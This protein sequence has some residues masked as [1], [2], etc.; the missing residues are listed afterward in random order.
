MS[1]PA[2]SAAVRGDDY[3]YVVAWNHACQA[4][5]DPNIESVSVED[6]GAGHFDDLAIRRL[7]D[8][9]DLYFQVKSSNSGDVAVDDDWLT[10]AATHRGRSP[11]QHFH[12]TW[13]SLT[14][15]GRPFQLKLLTN[16]GFDHGHPILGAMRDNLD[17]RVRV[18]SLRS[19]GARSAAGVTRDRWAAHLKVTV[20]EL[21]EFLEVVHWEQSGGE[22]SWRDSTKPLMTLAGLRADEDAIDVG[23]AI[24]RELV[25]TGAGPQTRAQLRQAVVD[26]HLAAEAT[27][28]VLAVHA[29]DR[30]DT[31]LAGAVTIDWVDRFTGDSPWRRHQVAD[32]QDWTVRFPADLA[33]ARADL[34]SSRSRRVLV[35][36][37]MRLGSYFAVAHELADVRGWVLTVDQRGEL[38]STDAPPEAGVTATVLADEHIGAG[39]DLA[40]AV[41]LSNDIVD[42]VRAYV[43]AES[44]SVD[45]LIALGP[46]G[47]PSGSA[48]PSQSWLVAWVGSAR[49]IIRRT[50]GGAPRV[51]LFVSAPAAAAMMLGHRWN[52]LPPATF[53]DFNHQTYFPTFFFQ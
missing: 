8:R 23:V 29:I 2:R 40:V 45:R 27:Q 43:K 3:Q 9:P 34:E 46:N 30:P 42:D 37:A 48:V 22:Q 24:M 28:Q 15:G 13:R 14:G 38:W 49:N 47:V 25:K 12:A 5:S 53:H 35:T 21:L 6:A 39:D 17:C 16:R 52:V 31:P 7:D 11:L 51:H 4:L 1:L 50:A 19:A 26:K 33:R 20:E 41:A 32:P 44:L 36:G 10:T 18:V